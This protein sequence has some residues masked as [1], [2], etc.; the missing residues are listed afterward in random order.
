L[1]VEK[2]ENQELDD[3]EQNPVVYEDMPFFTCELTTLNRISFAVADD[4]FYKAERSK[5]YPECTLIN[6]KGKIRARVGP[7]NREAERFGM[8]YMEDV[9]EP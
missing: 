4:P 8:E 9:R 7:Y 6:G 2:L 5:Y 1:Y 3:N